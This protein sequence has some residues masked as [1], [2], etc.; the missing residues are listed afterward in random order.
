MIEQ[1]EKT[2][3]EYEAKLKQ[4]NSNI[5]SFRNVIDKDSLEI[6]QGVAHLLEQIISDLEA[7]KS[8]AKKD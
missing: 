4:V 1:I 5:K 3:R 6:I 7:I 8:K 2:K